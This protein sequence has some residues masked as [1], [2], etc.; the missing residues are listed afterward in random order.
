MTRSKKVILFLALAFIVILYALANNLR[1]KEKER[2]L[3]VQDSKYEIPISSPIDVSKW[4][5]YRNSKYGFEV[6]YP[7]GLKI[8]VSKQQNLEGLY[9]S[10][11]NE[12]TDIAGLGIFKGTI[13]KDVLDRISPR[14]EVKNLVI[15]GIN[16]VNLS[17][18]DYD[19]YF[20]KNDLVYYFSGTL[21]AQE[22]DGEI[23]RMIIATFRFLE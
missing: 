8:D 11:L 17:D 5:T 7:T 18:T 14:P 10:F 3:P 23:I 21:F 15:N 6:K 2:P 20:E 1:Q 19:L 12:G 13:S 9:L 22:T 4:Q 16:M